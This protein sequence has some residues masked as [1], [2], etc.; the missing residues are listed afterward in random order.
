MSWVL[1]KSALHRNMPLWKLEQWLLPPIV[2][3]QYRLYRRDGRPTAFFTFGYLSAE[4]EARYVQS[5]Q[6]L[7][8]ADWRS[9]DRLWVMDFVAPFGDMAQVKQDFRS[10]VFVN[11]TGH[12][13]RARATNNRLLV[14]QFQGKTIPGKRPTAVPP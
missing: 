10:N 5:P 7:Q 9:G 6:S 12:S 8:P 11:T 1:S 2:L 3:G 13:L 14:R 4:V